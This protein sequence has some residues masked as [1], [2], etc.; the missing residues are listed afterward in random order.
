MNAT[1]VDT[2]AVDPEP[3]VVLVF[4]P[5]AVH[6][7]YLSMCGDMNALI[8]AVLFL[9]CVAVVCARCLLAFAPQDANPRALASSDPVIDAVV[10]TQDSSESK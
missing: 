3:D 1:L 2:V 8:V 7:Y 6:E 5:V 10:I 9:P 4:I